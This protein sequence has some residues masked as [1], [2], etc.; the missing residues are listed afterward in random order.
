M[1]SSSKF[2]YL[3]NPCYQQYPPQGFSVCLS[4]IKDCVSQFSNLL[5]THRPKVIIVKKIV[6]RHESFLKL[7]PF[8]VQLLGY[9]AY[10]RFMEGTKGFQSCKAQFLV[11]NWWFLTVKAYFIHLQHE[12]YP[13][14]SSSNFLQILEQLPS[15]AY[16]IK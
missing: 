12:K 15:D 2:C 3:T 11:W 10:N 13:Q 9:K 1:W 5:W 8:I 14:L 4:V 16:Q 6:T 7:C